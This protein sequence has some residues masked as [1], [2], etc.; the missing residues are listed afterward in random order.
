MKTGFQ[1]NASY[2]VAFEETAALRVVPFRKTDLQKRQSAS[3]V[4]GTLYTRF[5]S[6][7]FF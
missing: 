6:F 7:F 1:Q 5:F 2:M 4:N 3:P